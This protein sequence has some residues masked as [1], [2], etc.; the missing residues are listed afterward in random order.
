MTDIS[1]KDNYNKIMYFYIT[2]IYIYIYL[3]FSIFLKRTINL[4]M[5][6]EK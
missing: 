6:K 5:N 2:Y 3:Q 1:L 4:F